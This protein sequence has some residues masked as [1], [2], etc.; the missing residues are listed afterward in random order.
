[1]LS[2]TTEPS[3]SAASVDARREA[4]RGLMQ[5]AGKPPEICAVEDFS[6]PGPESAIGVR[7]YTP[8][9]TS[10]GPFP[11]LVF[12]HGGGLVAGSLD[13]HDS[14][15]R[16]LT[17]AIGCR[18][19]AVDY[20]LAPEH[21]FPAAV[22]DARTAWAWVMT[23][24]AELNLDP[25]RIG[26]AGDS[27]GGALAIAACD[28]ARQSGAAMPA[29][30]LLLCPITDFAAETPSRG[31]FASGYLIDKTMIA[32]DLAHCLPSGVTPDD[33]RISPLRLAGLSGLPPAFIHTAEFDPFR[34]EGEAYAEKLRGDGVKA[35][36]TCHQGMVHLFYAMPSVIPAARDAIRQIGTEIR[37]ALDQNDFGW[38][39]LKYES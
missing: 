28:A 18:T 14:L 10:A 22:T 15:C 9:A 30:Q 6:L 29:F 35:A 23:H 4:F 39:H 38:H 1:M 7:L 21:K 32:Q 17:A 5:F 27:A 36:V 20:R 13:T 24:A 2:V 34:D 12:F 25:E 3:A 16:S 31:A 37:V 19:I 26:V 8:I 33:P 11:G